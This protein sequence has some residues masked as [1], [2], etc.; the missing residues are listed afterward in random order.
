MIE[1]FKVDCLNI[2]EQFIPGL[3]FLV[4]G[5]LD[6]KVTYVKLL[7]SEQSL[8]EYLDSSAIQTQHVVIGV[9]FELF[10]HLGDGGEGSVVD[11]LSFGLAVGAN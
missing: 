4:A 1:L 10:L 2:S 7:Q 9:L 6:N 5:Q 8:D 3:N 11:E